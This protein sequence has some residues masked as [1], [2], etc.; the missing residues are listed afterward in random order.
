M[1]SEFDEAGAELP[2]GG[3]KSEMKDGLEMERQCSVIWLSSWPALKMS[4]HLRDVQ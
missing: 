2:R 1:G 3:K 4:T